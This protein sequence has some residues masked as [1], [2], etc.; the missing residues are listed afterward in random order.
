MDQV[1]QRIFLGEK[2]LQQGTAAH[3]WLGADLMKKTNVAPGTKGLGLGAAQHY[4]ID[5]GIITPGQQGAGE[6]AHHVQR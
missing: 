1:V 4:R 3:W 2:I 5:S 6:R